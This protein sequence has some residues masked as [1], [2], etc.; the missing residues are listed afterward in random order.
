[1]RSWG[2]V[3]SPGDAFLLYSLTDLIDPRLRLLY[4]EVIPVVERTWRGAWAGILSHSRQAGLKSHATS[5]ARQAPAGSGRL[6]RPSTDGRGRH[7]RVMGAGAGKPR[8]FDTSES[9]SGCL[10]NLLRTG[11]IWGGDW[12]PRCRPVKRKVSALAHHRYARPNKSN[13]G[14]SGPSDRGWVTR[15]PSR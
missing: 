4:Q 10:R 8:Y 6:R 2:I 11:L 5:S 13:A 9:T 15:C 3:V 7:R 12:A 1:M 14:E